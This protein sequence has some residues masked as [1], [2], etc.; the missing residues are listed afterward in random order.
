MWG[1]I[2]FTIA[3]V[4]CFVVYLLGLKAACA[5][6]AYSIILLFDDGVRENYKAKILVEIQSK[7]KEKSGSDYARFRMVCNGVRNLAIQGAN[8][9]FIEAAVSLVKRE[10]GSQSKG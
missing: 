4:C 5:L 9:N 10:V 7:L 8:D 2:C 1:W 6:E 3:V